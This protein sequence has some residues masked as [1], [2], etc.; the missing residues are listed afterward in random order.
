MEYIIYTDGG[1]LVNPGGKGAYGVVIIDTST[2]EI[3]QMMDAY[4]S[5]TN[6][7]ME[8]MA[9]IV[10]LEQLKEGDAAL[11]HSDSQYVINCY[12]GVWKKKKNVDLWKRMEAASKGKKI[13]MRWVRGH[14]GDLYNEMCDQLATLAMQTLPG[15]NDIGYAG[16]GTD[17][18]GGEK[19]KE[20]S[21]ALKIDVPEN[22][23]RPYGDVSEAWM[24]DRGVHEACAHQIF[25]LKNKKETSFKDYANLKTGGVDKISRKAV[26]LLVEEMTEGDKV[27]SVV[28]DYFSDE[29]MILSAMRWIGRGLSVPD[30]I[31]K[32]Q[33]D[34]EV[35]EKALRGRRR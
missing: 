31:R 18:H 28:S 3:K 16:D 27:L 10:A 29:K 26:S 5:T 15:K 21:R 20:Q 30:A 1:C 35:A 6:N 25:L 33:V 14:N 4:A 2:G 7:R 22:L 13:T 19:K 9:V 12:S 32:V 11:L 24:V 23:R 8:M 34:A 17:R